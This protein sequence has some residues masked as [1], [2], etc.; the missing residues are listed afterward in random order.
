[1][2]QK[3]DKEKGEISSVES[4]TIGGFRV[5]I[6][7]PAEIKPMN[8]GIPECVYHADK[9]PTKYEVCFQEAQRPFVHWNA[10]AGLAIVGGDLNNL[11]SGREMIFRAMSVAEYQRQKEGQILTHGAAVVSPEGKG[12]MILGNQ[13]AGKTSTSV[14]LGSRGYSLVGNDQVIFGQG[15]NGIS[16]FGGTKYLLLRQTI[17]QYQLPNLNS[18]VFPNGKKSKWDTKVTIKPEDIN[19]GCCY[20]IAP[21][22]GVFI[23]HLDGSGTED[24]GIARLGPSDLQSNLFLAEKFSRHINGSATPLI[25]DDGRLLALSPSFDD[26][27]TLIKRQEVIGSLYEIGVYKVWGSRINE[28]LD[29]VENATNG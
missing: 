20:D 2:V 22:F 7:F 4:T 12:I 17:E 29:L 10:E 21:V 8:L 23:I 26:Q 15:E 28:I 25:G 16:L 9:G 3:Y 5:N 27:E 18:V 11:R 6:D 13:G 24:A 19:M 14:G 1:M